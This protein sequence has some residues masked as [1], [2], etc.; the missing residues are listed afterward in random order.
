MTITP[1]SPTR[2]AV[3]EFLELEI[4]GRCQLTCPSLCYAK[5]GPA[6]GHG[7]M[8]T[9]DWKVL[10]SEAASI[11]VEKVQFIGGEPTMHPDFEALVHRALAVGIDVQVYSNLY[12]VKLEHWALFAHPKVSLATSYYS[13]LAEEH[14]RVTGRRGSHAATRANIVQA[15]HRRI[16]L[17]V[18]IVEVFDGQRTAQARE[19]LLA[20]G[21]RTINVDRVRSVGRGEVHVPSTADLC[22]RCAEGR[23]AVMSDGTVTPCVLGRFLRTGNAKT[24]GLANVFRGQP[25]ADT[26]ARI[27]RRPAATAGCTPAD[28]NDCDPANTPACDPAY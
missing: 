3:P 26:A 18:G 19:E 24:D 28:S 16:P 25:W 20:L 4:T 21:V 5:A 14:E 22:G 2:P 7:S 6:E 11:G 17:Q 10:I 27:S 12:R 8:T 23:A 13:D 9:D 15:I 1:E